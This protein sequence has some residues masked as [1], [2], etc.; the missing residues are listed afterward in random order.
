VGI[1]GYGLYNLLLF[2]FSLLLW[3][4]A[5]GCGLARLLL[6]GLLVVCWYVLDKYIGCLQVLLFFLLLRLED[7]V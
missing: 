6:V 5:F 4:M 3:L 7:R 1:D 2:L